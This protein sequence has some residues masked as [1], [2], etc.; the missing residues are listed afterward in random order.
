MH[1]LVG[2]GN[3]GSEY[4]NTR[5][6][7]GFMAVD[8]LVRRYSF[9]PFKEKCKGLLTNGTIG[10]EKVIIL[11][12]TTYM[13]LSGESVLAACT[14]YK[15]KPTQ[16]IVFHDDMDLV[17]GKVKVKQGGSAGGHNG[18]KSIDSQIGPEYWRVRIGTGHPAQ[19]EDV[20]NWVLH[21]FS[22][23][24]KVVIDQTLD[25]I[26]QYAELLLAGNEQTFMNRL[27]QK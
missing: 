6:N 5:H 18:L 22:K 2:L 24:D 16:V 17:V 12:P 23:E 14:F 4:A 7:I 26:A 3:P 19:K 15:I 13:N 1:L 25:Q 9:S 10:S 21:A 8:E 27:N 20:I 11:K